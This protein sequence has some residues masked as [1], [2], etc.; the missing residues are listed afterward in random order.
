VIAKD[1]VTIGRVAGAHGIQGGLKI[2][3]F[4]DS[5]ETLAALGTVTLRLGDGEVATREVL[6]LKPHGKALFLMGLEGVSDRGQ[7]EDLLGAEILIQRAQMPPLEDGNYYWCDLIG[8]AVYNDEQ[9]IGT[10]ESI[11]PTGSNDVYVVTDGEKETL[12]PALASVVREVDVNR[13][14]MRVTLPEGL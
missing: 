5:E 7:A 1:Y 11:S 9:Y 12:V 2:R 3:S 14:R 10:L 6:W 4:A 13:K 8:S